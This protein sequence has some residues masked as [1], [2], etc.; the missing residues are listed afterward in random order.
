MNEFFPFTHG[1][2]KS[3]GRGA[4]VTRHWRLLREGELCFINTHTFSHTQLWSSSSSSKQQVPVRC[5]RW[6]RVTCGYVC[7]SESPVLC[8][9]AASISVWVLSCAVS[10]LQPLPV[11]LY[12][13]ASRPEGVMLDVDSGPVARYQKVRLGDQPVR[14]D[15]CER[16][17]TGMHQVYFSTKR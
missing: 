17:F 5:V 1:K 10:L 8:A 2:E 11:V 7:Q 14:F 3:R 13:S 16:D 12:R 6:G 9:T 4:E 15:P